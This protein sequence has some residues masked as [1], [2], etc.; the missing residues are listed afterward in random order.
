MPFRF[1][2]LTPGALAD[3]TL[4]QERPYAVMRVGSFLVANGSVWATAAD[5]GREFTPMSWLSA[6]DIDDPEDL[7]LADV[8]AGRMGLG[9]FEDVA[10]LTSR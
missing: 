2:V 7:A 9:A 4:T 6:L 10:T 5:H 8:I 3:L 1:D